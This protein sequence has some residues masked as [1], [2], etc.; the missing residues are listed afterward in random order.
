MT[1][2]ERLE[3]LCLATSL[4]SIATYDSNAIA[5]F[6]AQYNIEMMLDRAEELLIKMLEP[7]VRPTTSKE[8]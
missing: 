8:D 4:E 2:E 7:Y 5:E 1:T 3:F 6:N